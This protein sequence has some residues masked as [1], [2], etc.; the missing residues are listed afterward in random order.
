MKV[1]RIVITLTVLLSGRNLVAADTNLYIEAYDVGSNYIQRLMEAT[2]HGVEGQTAASEPASKQSRDEL[3]RRALAECGIHWPAGSSIRYV[4]WLGRVVIKNTPANLRSF[5]SI[6]PQS[7]VTTVL[8]ES[9]LQFVAFE[10]TNI[11]ELVRLD[12]VSR[13]SLLA[14]WNEG[15]AVLVAAPHVVSHSGTQSVVSA[16]LITPGG[17]Q[18]SELSVKMTQWMSPS[19]GE[20]ELEVKSDLFNATTSLSLGKRVLLVGGGPMKDDR[21]VLYVFATAWRVSRDGKRYPEATVEPPH[22]GDVSTRAR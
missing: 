17:G 22:A 16:C 6:L 15:R 21:Q 18:S 7:N 20:S 8:I 3:I 1:L 12:G 4:D 11:N 19:G 5:E 14:L 9:E 10:R 13:E 2:R